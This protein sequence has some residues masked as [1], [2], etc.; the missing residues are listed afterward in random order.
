M[1]DNS[2]LKVGDTV[3]I[4][5]VYHN[6]SVKEPEVNIYKGVVTKVTTSRIYVDVKYL[7]RNQENTFKIVFEYRKTRRLYATDKYSNSY[8]SLFSSEDEV[9]NNQKYVNDKREASKKLKKEFDSKVTTLTLEKT[10]KLLEYI[11]KL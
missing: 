1:I 7:I 4:R 8:Y 11:Q 9:N 3:W 6:W 5:S 2:T 10:L